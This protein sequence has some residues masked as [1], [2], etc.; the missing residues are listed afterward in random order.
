[1]SEPGSVSARNC[2][3]I[4]YC[5]QCRWLLRAA[6]M[7]QE[8][9][10]TFEHELQALTLIPGGGGVFEVRA[11]GAVVWSRSRDGGF[12]EIGQLKRLVRDHVAPGRNLGHLDRAA[13]SGPTE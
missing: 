13:E 1:M 6:W 9:L 7:A 2:V 5:T 11:N 3:E 12:P 10:S 4:V 8:L